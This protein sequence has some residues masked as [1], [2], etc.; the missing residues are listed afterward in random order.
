MLS[1][2]AVIAALQ[3]V[4]RDAS[5]AGGAAPDCADNVRSAFKQLFDA[6]T[7]NEGRQQLSNVFR[8][9]KGLADDKEV[10][11]LG[12]WIQVRDLGVWGSSFGGLEGSV[13]KG[14]SGGGR[15]MVGSA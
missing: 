15:G 12:Y 3:V 9:C 6:G 5:Q 13:V 2:T 1:H 8:L 14:G 11:A 4:T 7:S 10:T